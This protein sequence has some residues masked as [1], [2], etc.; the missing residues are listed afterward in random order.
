ME[1]QG[2]MD[3]LKTSDQTFEQNYELYCFFFGIFNL[4][5]DRK[6]KFYFS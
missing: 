3:E 4:K 6:F 2:T 1:I 5:K